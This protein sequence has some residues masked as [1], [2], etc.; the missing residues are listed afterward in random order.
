MQKYKDSIL[1][2]VEVLGHVIDIDKDGVE[3]INICNTGKTELG[4]AL[5]IM[6]AR[7]FNTFLGATSR[8]SLFIDAITIPDMNLDLVSKKRLTR[9]DID[10][11]TGKRKVT[12]PNYWSLLAYALCCKISKYKNI[13]DM[14]K[15]N[16]LPYTSIEKTATS[17]FFNLKQQILQ[18]RGNMIKYVAIVTLIEKM[19]KEDKFTKENVEQFCLDLRSNPE[20]DILDGIACANKLGEVKSS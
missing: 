13:Q 9:E 11:I 14:M 7:M 19:I 2:E 18:I 10:S 5:S 4:R 20:K 8:I 3:F 12:V 1:N 15:A 16:T 6:D 17:D